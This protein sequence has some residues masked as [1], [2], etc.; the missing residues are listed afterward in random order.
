MLFVVVFGKKKEKLRADLIYEFFF[1]FFS[2][3]E[4]YFI[5]ESYSCLKYSLFTEVILLLCGYR[6]L[7]VVF[8]PYFVQWSLT[9]FSSLLVAGIWKIAL[10]YSQFDLSDRRKAFLHAHCHCKYRRADLVLWKTH[11]EYLLYLR[12]HRPL[13]ISEGLSSLCGVIQVSETCLAV[14]TL[15][16]SGNAFGLMDL[17]SF[18]C[19][20]CFQEFSSSFFLKSRSFNKKICFFIHSVFVSISFA[21]N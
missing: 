18:H 4:V 9:S 3:S 20:N 11:L 5:A 10:C 1:F 8:P 17:Q 21:E 16:F 7:L 12:K 15:F 14:S 13:R 2:S 19:C 6:K